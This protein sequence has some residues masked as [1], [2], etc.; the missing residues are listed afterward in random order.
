MHVISQAIA[1]QRLLF[2][3]ALAVV[4]S[5]YAAFLSP[6]LAGKTTQLWTTFTALAF[7]SDVTVTESL[8]CC[9]FLFVKHPHDVRNRVNISEQELIVERMSSVYSV[10]R[11]VGTGS[12]LQ[13]PHTIANS[14]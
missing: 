3:V 5:I 2:A 9:I 8:S 12:T 11:R 4:A 13:P 14:L 6:A 1:G 10:F 7:T